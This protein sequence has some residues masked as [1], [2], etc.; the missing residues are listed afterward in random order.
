[1][2]F[3]TDMDILTIKMNFAITMKLRF[4]LKYRIAL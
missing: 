1:M 4:K 2:T 3:V